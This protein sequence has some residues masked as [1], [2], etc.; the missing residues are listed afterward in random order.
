MAQLWWWGYGVSF[1]G[2]L[3]QEEWWQCWL[4]IPFFS[5]RFMKESVLGSDVYFGGCC[6]KGCWR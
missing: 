1:R 6:P 5:G 2:M 3:F 4:W